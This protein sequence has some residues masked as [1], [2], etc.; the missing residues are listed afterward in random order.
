MSA[1]VGF[2][3]HDFGRHP[4][5]DVDSMSRPH[6][7][8]HE[9]YA[10]RHGHYSSEH[11]SYPPPL[12]SQ[13]TQPPR[14]P[15]MATMISTVGVSHPAMSNGRETSYPGGRPGYYSDYA[16]PSPVGQTPPQFPG[17]G[18]DPHAM[19][20]RAVDIRRSPTLSSTA[21]D[22]SADEVA[23]EMRM[24]QMNSFRDHHGQGLS[25]QYPHQPPRSSGNS[26]HYDGGLPPVLMGG[27]SASTYASA[28]GY[29]NGR[30]APPPHLPQSPPNSNQA[31]ASPRQ[32][33]KSMSISNLLR[34]DSATATTPATSAAPPVNAMNG[35]AITPSRP[36][37]PPPSPSPIAPTSEY[38]ISVRQQPYAARSCGF[39]ERD[40][41]V[42]DPPPIVQLTIHD[43]SL[44]PEEHGR[45]L[46]HQFSVVHCSIYDE[47]GERDMSAM[48]ED[49]RQQRRLM[50]TL[51]ASPFV[52][53]DENG[54]EG[55]FFC[56]PDLSCR[57]PG[58]FRLKF[59]L[60]V[61]DPMR[62]CMGDRS[63]IV[64]TAMSEVFCVFNAKD[65]PG[66][67]ASTGLTK[68]LKEQGCL[69]SIKKGNEKR[70]TPGS[71]G[72]RKLEEDIEEEDEGDSEGEGDGEKRG[73]K[74]AKRSA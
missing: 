58:S 69:I 6:H 9:G 32:E 11:P 7:N 29:L 42:I 22:R 45:R 73:R 52:G 33:A 28:P 40:R 38:R 50:G 62:M 66:M 8:Y 1:V 41:R 48:P 4:L 21:S 43:P 14:L 15:S 67:K 31:S 25:R 36:S 72:S 12:P 63:K 34:S 27:T 64:A 68:R 47:K 55:C 74:R 37:Y 54:E 24:R 46:R 18:N 30:P 35:S 57:T 10:L 20:R 2:A 56:F 53:Q 16:T 60:V 5:L 59:A 19:S 51:V 23:H 3:P 61:L 65:F 49:F 44:S 13:L 70:E 39:G 26:L 17:P 71:T